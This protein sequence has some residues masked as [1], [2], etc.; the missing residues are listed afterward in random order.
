MK[1]NRFSNF[2][3]PF[4]S[5]IYCIFFVVLVAFFNVLSGFYWCVFYEGVSIHMR[6]I[7]CVDYIFRFA[8]KCTRC[9]SNIVSADTAMFEVSQGIPLLSTVSGCGSSTHKLSKECISRGFK[10]TFMNIKCTINTAALWTGSWNTVILPI[11]AP[12][13][14]NFG[15]VILS[16]SSIRAFAFT[17]A[18]CSMAAI[19]KTNGVGLPS[20]LVT[21]TAS[22]TTWFFEYRNE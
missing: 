16:N 1:W 22:E 20:S 12:R 5:L 10:L 2:I 15:A 3:S 4:H 13:L 11:F 7:M 6:D 9:S 8:P 18:I 19:I 21:Y 14:I 17:L